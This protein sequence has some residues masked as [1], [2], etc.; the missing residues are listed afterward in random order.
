MTLEEIAQ[1][2]VQIINALA[3]LQGVQVKAAVEHNAFAIETAAINAELTLV[4]PTFGLAAI[5]AAIADLKAQM[6]SDDALIVT[7]ILTRQAAGAP[8]TLPPT[9]PASYD[10]GTVAAQ[11]WNYPLGSL[12]VQ[13]GDYMTNIGT[14][15]VHMSD[16]Q[17]EMQSSDHNDWLISGNWLDDFAPNPDTSLIPTIDKS[18][19]HATD[20]NLRAWL[21]R[22]YSTL[23]FTWDENGYAQFRTTGSAGAWLYTFKWSEADFQAY[24]AG[25]FRPPRRGAPVWPGF[26]NAILGTE[27]PLTDGLNLTGPMD[28]L[29]VYIASVPAKY[30]VWNFSRGFVSYRYLGAIS[31]IS[32]NNDAESPQL[33][34]FNDAVYTP[35]TMVQAAVV[36]ARLVPG[37]VATCQPFT[38][39]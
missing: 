36:Q 11:V 27:V 25:K 26:S 16:A 28:G 33:L 19:I 31:F 9:P 3:S 29:L 32:D 37:V 17:V 1:L 7:D 4:N 24:K 10:V 6:I 5:Q 20:V 23:A 35:H 30:P 14:M 21:E 18:T 2:L 12:P 39:R 22:V 34:G 15:A 13:A 38:V 8:V